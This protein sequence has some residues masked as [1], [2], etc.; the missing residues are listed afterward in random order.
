MNFDRIAPFYN[1]M[2]TWFA[3]RC[4]QACRTAFLGRLSVP[5]QVL[6][7]GEGHGRFLVPFR[8]KFPEAEIVIIDGSERMLEICARRLDEEGLSKDGITFVHSMIEDWRGDGRTFDLIV[9][10]FLLDCLTE[11][12]LANA[13]GNLASMA[14]PEADWLI[15]D[16]QI[17]E[18]GA[19]KW[20]SRVILSLLYG[21][22]R[23]TAR[24]EA[25]ELVPPDAALRSV[26]FQRI[27][28][29]TWDWE[30]L[31]SEWWRRDGSPRP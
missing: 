3:G 9:T 23:I 25:R 21:F 6:M 27:G 20:R 19:R 13:V 31:K 7:A 5:H 17:A 2:E 30:L 28:R 15:A 8:R 4:L 10:N 11:E 16:F 29:K 1:A 14:S 12:Q 22:F 24:L 26:G 18:K